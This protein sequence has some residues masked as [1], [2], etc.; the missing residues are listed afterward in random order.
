MH[1]DVF[2]H[3][4]Q[5][6]IQEE[7]DDWDNLS[8]DLEITE[9][10]RDLEDFQADAWKSSDECLTACTKTPQCIQYS[11]LDGACKLGYVIRLGA[12]VKDEK[13]KGMVSGWMT[14]RVDG[15]KHDMEPCE[16]RWILKNTD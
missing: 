7:R 10:S 6:E 3:F 1:R 5:P 14:G 4:V 8:Q 9:T 13:E 16:P 15:F 12:T 11:Y 2:E